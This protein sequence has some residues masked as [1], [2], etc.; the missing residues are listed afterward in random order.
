MSD[1]G[2]RTSPVPRRPVED[3]KRSLAHSD[4]T[5]PAF[6]A[7]AMIVVIAIL[8][9]KKVPAAIGKA[10]DKKIAHI[11][12]Q[13]DEASALRKEAEE[14]K[15]ENQVQGCVGRRGSRG[16]DR[17]GPRKPRRSWPRL[18]ST[19]SRW[20]SA[21]RRWPRP[22]SRPR[23]APRSTS[24]VDRRQG[25]HGGCSEADRRAQRRQERPGAGRPGD[26]STDQVGIHCWCWPPG[27]LCGEMN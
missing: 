21:A 20:S 13:L 22:R 18:K 7:L 9:W 25:G 19:P 12:E 1:P 10:L 15:R 5:P 26:F 4:L 16:D 6:I 24:C 14:L 17:A 3:M 27:R 8:I 11:R 2:R 23:S